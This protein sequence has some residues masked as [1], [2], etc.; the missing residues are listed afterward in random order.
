MVLVF[1]WDLCIIT[2]VENITSLNFQMQHFKNILTHRPLMK[3]KL[4]QGTTLIV[5]RYAFSGVAFTSAKPV[6]L[7]LSHSNSVSIRQCPYRGHEG[8]TTA[9]LMCSLSRV[10]LWTGAWNLTWDCQ[11]RTLLCFYSSAQPRLLSE[12][13]LEKRDM[14]PTVSKEQFNRNLISWWRIPPSTGRYDQQLIP[15]RHNKYVLGW[16]YL[17]YVAISIVCSR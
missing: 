12:V 8:S 11:S 1:L 7:Y 10:S 14:R 16:P 3:K 6:R 4:E 9:S 17:A 13:S 15:K 2:K 5:D